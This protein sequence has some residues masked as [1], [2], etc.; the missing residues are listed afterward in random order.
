MGLYRY[1]TGDPA[2]FADAAGIWRA[3]V[4][5]L[6]VTTV[7]FSVR[8]GELDVRAWGPGASWALTRARALTGLADDV[9]G[10][11]PDHP[12]LRQLHARFSG[13]RFARTD[14]VLESLVPAILSQKITGKEAFAAWRRLLRSHGVPAPGPIPRPMWAPPTAAVMRT[15]D[16]AQWH[17]FGVDRA[18]RSTIRRALQRAAA[19]E[20]LSKLH[21]DDAAERMQSIPGIGVW[22]AAEV[23]ER[24]WGSPD[25]P[26]FGDYHIPSSVGVALAGEPVDDDGMA[27]LLE[28]Y[29]PH[30]GRV[31]RLIEL[32][33]IRRERRGPKRT[34]PDYRSI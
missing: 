32:A 22:T 19:L 4:T 16:D 2:Y 20:R 11:E 12:L 13:V 9:A 27:A 21:P 31:V 23:A 26:S 8:S 15:L 33:G 18:R 6:G 7:V 10:F 5:P 28:P 1:G 24:A 29:R 3:M 14:L 34:V 25:H 17:A 30:R